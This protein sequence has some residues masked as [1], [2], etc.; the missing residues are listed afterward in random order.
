M[1]HPDVQLSPIDELL[2]IGPCPQSG[3]HEF[4]HLPSGAPPSRDKAGV[5]DLCPES[6]IVLVLVPSDRK[7]MVGAQSTNP[8][9]RRFDPLAVDSSNTPLTAAPVQAFLVSK[10]ELTVGQWRRLRRDSG[11]SGDGWDPAD[12]ALLPVTRV[13]PADLMVGLTAVGLTLPNEVEW[14][15][16]ARAGTDTPW[17]TGDDR[18]SVTRVGNEFFQAAQTAVKDAATWDEAIAILDREYFPR[19]VGLSNPNA[20]GLFDIHG[21][22]REVCDGFYRPNQPMRGVWAVDPARATSAILVTRGGCYA[23]VSA[24]LVRTVVRGGVRAG[25]PYPTI[26]ARPI[27]RLARAK[28]ER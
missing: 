16:A 15:Y 26:G 23:T 13:A 8:K 2:P 1:Q 4:A 9:A 6:A 11:E 3:L 10:Y 14:E 17:W 28:E 19:R 27:L 12:D 18:Q 5:F 7:F 24:D 20:F 22:V 25:S 21:N